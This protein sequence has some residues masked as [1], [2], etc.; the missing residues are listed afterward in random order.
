M[1]PI[2]ELAGRLEDTADFVGDPSNTIRRDD[3]AELLRQAASILSRLGSEETIARTLFWET[4]GLFYATTDPECVKV[5]RA[6]LSKL[7]SE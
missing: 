1:T 3:L 5:A 6:V 2:K 4:E 7:V